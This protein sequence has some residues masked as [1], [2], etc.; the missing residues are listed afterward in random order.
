MHM[1][2]IMCLYILGLILDPYTVYTIIRDH[3]YRG[4]MITMSLNTISNFI[5]TA[6]HASTYCSIV[7]TCMFV[8]FSLLIGSTN[9]QRKQIFGQSA[10]GIYM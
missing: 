8:V 1:N 3:Y 10:C 7:R 2:D 6:F 4:I 9:V 5:Q